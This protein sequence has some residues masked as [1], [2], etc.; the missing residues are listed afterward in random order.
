MDYAHKISI[1]SF[2]IPAGISAKYLTEYNLCIITN[3]T[4]KT[5]VS[6]NFPDI[7]DGQAILLKE[8]VILGLDLQ[9]NLTHFQDY[10]KCIGSEG[11]FMLC[12]RSH[13]FSVHIN[14]L[15]PLY[16]I[17]NNKQEINPLV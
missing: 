7:L 6:L 4:A 15:W 13:G 11:S 10:L 12:P 2:T 5:K 1:M 8:N 17:S 14:S 3:K 9:W 16:F